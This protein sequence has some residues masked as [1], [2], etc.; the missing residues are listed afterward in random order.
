MHL[1]SL[2]Q[3]S[4]SSLDHVRLLHLEMLSSDVAGY[5]LP[6]LQL[7]SPVPYG[8]VKHTQNQLSALH[9]K[10][11][12]PHITGAQISSYKRCRFHSFWKLYSSHLDMDNQEDIITS[13]SH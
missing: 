8:L 5:L 13:L 3:Y 1:R 7:I 6:G 4:I 2:T 10:K 9:L 11:H 12:K